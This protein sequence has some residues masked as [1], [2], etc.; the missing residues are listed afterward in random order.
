MIFKDSQSYLDNEIVPADRS[1]ICINC[2][3]DWFSHHGWACPSAPKSYYLLKFNVIKP[4]YRYLTLSMK[5]SV[6]KTTSLT[7]VILKKYINECPCGIVPSMC[8]YHKD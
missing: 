3:F 8:D 6:N 5:N 2:Q 1:E 4:N 7:D